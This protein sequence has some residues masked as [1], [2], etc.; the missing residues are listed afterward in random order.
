MSEEHKG[1]PEAEELEDSELD[2]ISGGLGL[3][4]STP[5]SRSYEAWPCKWY[6][7]ELDSDSSAAKKG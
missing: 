3:A 6:V 2:Q 4:S 1:K 5:T 7:P